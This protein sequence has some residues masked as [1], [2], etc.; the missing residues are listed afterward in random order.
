MKLWCAALNKPWSWHWIAYPGVWFTVLLP[1][2]VYLV[3]VRRHRNT[4][5][6][7]MWTFLTAMVIF[8]VASDWPVGTLGAGYLASVHMLEYVLYTLVV[9]PLML[10]GT[11][12]WMARRVLGKL[13][14]TRAHEWLAQHLFV[15]GL[16]FNIVLVITHSPIGVDTLRS[17][18]L[19]SFA[20]DMSWL[21]SGIILWLP[22]LN[23]IKEQR[24]HSFAAKMV[25][26]FVSAGIV[27]IV[28]ASFLTFA[29]YPLYSTYELAPRVGSLT[30][31]QDQQLA[32]ITMKLGMVP[33]IWGALAV[34]FFRWAAQERAT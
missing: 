20:M 8:W 32:G 15:S 23:P 12:E 18:Q 29:S 7:T 31:L 1:T 30:A 26:L 5:R 3:A 24:T 2:I 21:A 25:Y 10:L 6:K 17:S 11:P 27:P 16:I 9:A 14:L 19:G 34:M 22:I 28:P 4:D 33:V 13:H